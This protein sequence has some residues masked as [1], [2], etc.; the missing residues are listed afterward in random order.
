[1]PISGL[2]FIAGQHFPNATPLSLPSRPKRDM[3]ALWPL[4]FR[5]G[6]GA[7]SARL[8]TQ[9]RSN[10]TPPKPGTSEERSRAAL[11]QPEA[12]TGAATAPAAH[13]F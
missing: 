4:P 11:T 6:P 13:P 3:I 8:A 9:Q 5:E 7:G 10:G 12:L 2:D 1:M